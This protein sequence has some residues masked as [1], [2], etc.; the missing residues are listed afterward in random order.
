MKHTILLVFISIIGLTTGLAIVNI[1]ARPS[2]GNMM[3]QLGAP[4][5][6]ISTLA[7]YLVYTQGIKHNFSLSLKML[8]PQIRYDHLVI[9]IVLGLIGGEIVY[10]YNDYNLTNIL[11][12]M[13]TFALYL[14]TLIL[15]IRGLGGKAVALVIVLLPL[16]AYF[17]F[18][19]ELMLY[20]S[21]SLD[22]SVIKMTLWNIEIIAF[23]IFFMVFYAY[24]FTLRCPFYWGGKIS[25]GIALFLV[26]DLL[27]ALNSGNLA[28]G[29]KIVFFHLLAV[30]VF[31]VIINSVR[32]Q[33][34]I[35]LIVNAIILMVV[36]SFIMNLYLNRTMGYGNMNFSDL[37]EMRTRLGKAY[38]VQNIF[39]QILVM[40]IPLCS[41]A[42]ILT[43]NRFL[44]G[45]RMVSFFVTILIL[46]LTFSRNG[47][48]TFIISHILLLAQKRVKIL[49]MFLT[50]V[51][52]LLWFVYPTNFQ[53]LVLKRNPKDVWYS[54]PIQARIA[55]WRASVGMFKDHPIF[56][57]GLNQFELHYGKYGPLYFTGVGEDR[58]LAG[59]ISAHNFYLNVL[60]ESG[61]FG[62]VS[63]IY[64]IWC[65]SRACYHLIVV[66]KGHALRNAF[67][68]IIVGIVAFFVFSLFGGKGFSFDNFIIPGII[69][70]TL[71]GLV[72]AQYRIITCREET[73]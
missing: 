26:A 32:V 54:T 27:S 8:I 65:V 21:T 15:I 52:L 29:I 28:N 35:E 46:F 19:Y 7:L 3:R 68:G 64:L 17:R 30:S 2:I 13:I 47:W 23:L 71:V 14:I 57:V 16:I 62:F 60:A 67:M 42:V 33:K 59:L 38:I 73:Q 48:L 44:G 18:N 40:V 41:T 36:L 55:A 20:E 34:D 1:I 5:I 6:V 53:E 24:I 39:A 10:K 11:I 49:L 51:F 31:F 69:F 58:A 4:I 9:A 45:F 61:I 66:T 25:V 50:F 43:T 63:L 70:W 56:G 22:M 12:A 37:F 72:V